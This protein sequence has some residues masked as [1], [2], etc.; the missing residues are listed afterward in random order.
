MNNTGP[1]IQNLATRIV[2]KAIPAEIKKAIP[3][4]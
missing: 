4:E 2:K 1:A 3:A